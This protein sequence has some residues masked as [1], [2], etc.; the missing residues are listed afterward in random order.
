MDE[1]I[2]EILTEKLNHSLN[3]NEDIEKLISCFENVDY[4]S[5]Y[6]GIL[7]GRLYLSLIHI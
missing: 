1:K 5:F 6:T 3:Q 2:K 7:I 4:N